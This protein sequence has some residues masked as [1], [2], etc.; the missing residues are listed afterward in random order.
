MAELCHEH[1]QENQPWYALEAYL[2][3]EECIKHKAK[4]PEN[5]PRLKG[6]LC[7]QNY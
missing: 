3:I 4:R 2:L 5:C 1:C 6:H 7:R